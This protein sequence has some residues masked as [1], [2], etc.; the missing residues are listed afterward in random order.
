VHLTSLGHP[1]LGDPTYGGSKVK[2]LEGVMIP[3]VMLHARTMGFTHPLSGEYRE[4]SAPAPADF[5][6]VFEALRAASPRK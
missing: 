1:L 5:E 6:G 2:T 3:R 4:F